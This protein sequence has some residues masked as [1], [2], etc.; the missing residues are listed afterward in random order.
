M[1]AQSMTQSDNTPNNANVEQSLDTLATQLPITPRAY[2]LSIAKSAISQNTLVVLPTGLGKTVISVLVALHQMQK[3]PERKILI[4]APTRP[5]VNQHLESFTKVL[6]DFITP[7]QMVVFTGQTSP[8]KRAKLFETAT[9]IFSTP[10]GLENDILAGRIKLRDISLLVFDEAHRATGEYSYVWVSK[11][12]QKQAQNPLILGLTASPGTDKATVLEVM[13]NLAIQKLEYREKT[14]PDVKPYIKETKVSYVEVPF[15]ENYSQIHTHLHKAYL[16]TLQELKSAGFFTHKVASSIRKTELLQFVGSLQRQIAQEGFTPEIATGISAAARA[17][18]ISHAVELIETQGI[19]STY[20]YLRAL[21]TDGVNGKTKAAKSISQNP[22]IRTAFVKLRELSDSESTHPKLTKVCDIVQMTL[23]QNPNAKIIIFSQYRDTIKTINSKINLFTNVTAEMFVGQ[24]KKNG[25]G[26]SQKQ[27]LEMVSKFTSGE[28]NVLCMSSVGEEGLDIPSVD[29]VIF[30][31]PI[32]SAIRTIQRRG[33]TGRLE[34]GHVIVLM[35]TGTRD[36]AF[37]WVAQKKEQNMYGILADLTSPSTKATPKFIQP[38]LTQSIPKV[39][40]PSSTQQKENTQP[41]A[42]PKT[43]PSQ[44]TFEEEEE[45]SLC[46]IIV[47]SR[48]KSSKTLRLMHEM[49]I[50]LELSSLQTGDYQLSQDVA[51]EFKRVSDFVDS[52]VDGRL[53]S[54]VKKLKETTLKPLIIVEGEESLFGQR[55]LH[56]NAIYGMISTISISYQVPILFTRNEQDTANLLFMIAR[57]E[58]Q[59]TRFNAKQFTQHTLKPKSEHEQL[60]YIVEAFPHIGPNVAEKLLVRFSTLERLSC[61]TMSEIRDIE[62]IGEKTAQQIWQ[63]CHL[64]YK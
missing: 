1:D 17:L 18:K 16:D 63:M 36:V 51:V 54:Q 57:R 37:R 49:P 10:Q 25:H 42:P 14:A 23:A 53:L 3:F 30:Y 50:K 38:T 39:T 47:D 60:R 48:E 20:A 6:S 24:A 4:L 29:K 52:I 12:Y 15:P 2:Q 33:R 58:Q 46:T 55:N 9:F 32:P 40:N 41:P 34:E 27:Q 64:E 35:T 5:L 11:Q 44:K 56:P 62:G 26:L 45:E 8:Q 43:Q 21:I 61:A 31:E 59:E 22:L 19:P 7:E 13:D 28:F